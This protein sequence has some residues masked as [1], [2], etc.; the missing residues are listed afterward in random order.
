MVQRDVA[1][2]DVEHGVS[3]QDKDDEGDHHERGEKERQQRHG[4]QNVDEALAEV[5]EFEVGL[6]KGGAAQRFRR[7][8]RGQCLDEQDDG[9]NAAEDENEPGQVVPEAVIGEGHGH[10]LSKPIG[11]GADTRQDCGDQEEAEELRFH[12]YG[13]ASHKF[14]APSTFHW[15]WPG[16]H[17]C[18]RCDFHCRVNLRPCPEADCPNGSAVPKTSGLRD[19]MRQFCTGLSQ[20]PNHHGL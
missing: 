6:G 14:S 20:S 3:L 7:V 12:G 1:L 2:R 16:T 8:P 9:K 5:R 19:S 4:K 13:C 18:S 15:A 17:S 11:C 10:Q